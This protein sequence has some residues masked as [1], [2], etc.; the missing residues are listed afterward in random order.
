MSPWRIVWPLSIPPPEADAYARGMKGSLCPLCGSRGEPFSHHRKQSRS[1]SLC[2]SCGLVFQDGGLPTQEEERS[3]YEL[4][5]NSPDDPGYRKWLESFVRK[6]VV[7]RYSSGRILDFGSGPRP[8]LSEILEEKGYPVSSYDPFFSPCWPEDGPFSLILLCEVLEH[9]YEPVQAFR[10]LAAAAAADARLAV[11]TEFLPSSDPEVFAPWW[12]KEDITHVRFYSPSSLRILGE[13]SGWL[14][15]E[16]DGSSL[17]V[18]RLE[19]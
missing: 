9:V 13:R 19:K 2:A 15:E 10:S 6:A 1:F 7:P 17:A 12:Y 8:V 18:F 11:R 14:L 3:R 5:N 4:H 16:D